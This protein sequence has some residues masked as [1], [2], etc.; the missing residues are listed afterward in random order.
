MTS[1][2]QI[3]DTDKRIWTTPGWATDQEEVESGI[4]YSFM[5]RTIAVQE[6]DFIADD[7]TPIRV[8]VYAT[9]NLSAI[10]GELRI[11][12]DE[13]QLL[14]GDMRLRVSEAHKLVRS[15]SECLDAL[16]GEGWGLEGRIERVTDGAL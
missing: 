12:R 14:I 10:S 4:R 8:E 3:N 16:K 11:S 2:Q 6:A 15:I 13:V 7:A 1:I 9:D 5:A